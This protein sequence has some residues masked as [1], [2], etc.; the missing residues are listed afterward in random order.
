MKL[1][2]YIVVVTTFLSPLTAFSDSS[3]EK[4]LRA[5]EDG[6][7]AEVK[8]LLSLGI[9]PNTTDSKGM[10]VLMIAARKGEPRIVSLL[11]AKRANVGQRSPA[12]DTALLMACLN[13]NAV[14]IQSLLDAGGEL[15]PK[16]GWTPLQYAA[17]AG[18]AGAVQLLLKRGAEK[19]AVAPNGYTP[20]MLAARNGKL[21]AAKALLY[22]DPDV[23][24]R[25]AGGDTA[26]RIARKRDMAELVELLKRSGAV[27]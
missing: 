14:V 4:M 15:N 22:A 2:L 20:L 27:E 26:L 8:R 7:T 23:N 17:F 6:E 3:Y 19:D 12:G 16:Q 18:H 9:D 11:I 1:L 25:T 10:S 21:E 13:G 5:V 24:F